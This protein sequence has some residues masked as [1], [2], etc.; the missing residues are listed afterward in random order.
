[1][2]YYYMYQITNAI[3]G[4]IYVGVHETNNLNDG[5]MGSG[6]LL[7]ES[8]QKLGKENFTKDILAFF[9]DS[10]SMYL[11][12]RNYVDLEFVKRH[13]TYNLQIGGTNGFGPNAWKAAQSSSAKKKRKSTMSEKKISQ[14]K[15]NTQFG[16]MWITN[17]IINSKIKSADNIPSGWRKG[18]I[19]PSGFGDKISAK[20]KGRTLED[21]LGAEEACK[22]K[23]IISAYQTERHKNRKV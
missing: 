11:A 2:R 4:K 19:M 5:Y 13:D 8:I 21:L 14:G 18:R 23:E 6:R 15:T 3:D 20:L 12:E 16:T 1:M 7:K 17:G 22:K 10:N 9:E